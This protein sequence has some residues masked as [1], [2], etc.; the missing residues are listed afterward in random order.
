[1]PKTRNGKAEGEAKEK[2][3]KAAEAMFEKGDFTGAAAAADDVLR[4][5][6]WRGDL[7]REGRAFRRPI[8]RRASRVE[9]KRPPLA[10][11]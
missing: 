1:M 5:A 4:A 2:A 8:P 9:T 7:L 11:F 10:Q 3:L 6:A